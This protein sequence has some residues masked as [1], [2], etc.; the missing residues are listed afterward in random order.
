MAEVSALTRRAEHARALREH[1]LRV[2]GRH[3]FQVRLDA[4][5]SAEELAPPDLVIVACKGIDLET[6]ASRL[7][8]HWPEATVMTVQNGLGA[9]AILGR[10]GDWRQLP[11]CVAMYQS[12]P[13]S[14]YGFET[15]S[16]PTSR[17]EHCC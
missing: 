12:P 16:T 7:E 11:A 1:G 3:Q 10:F 13:M 15:Y 6:V 5:P 14:T 4:A 17:S 8:G 2:T 9:D